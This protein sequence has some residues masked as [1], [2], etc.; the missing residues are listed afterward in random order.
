[1]TVQELANQV[2]ARRKSAW[3]RNDPQTAIVATQEL[4][5]DDE[6]VVRQVVSEAGYSGDE[7]ED[8]VRRVSARIVG[9][10]EALADDLPADGSD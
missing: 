8:V 7:L 10:V 5:P 2:M 1:M 4:G 6:R 9:R 3:A